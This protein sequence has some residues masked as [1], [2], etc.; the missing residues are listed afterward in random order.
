MTHQSLVHELIEKQRPFVE[1]LAKR[2]AIFDHLQTKDLPHLL[3]L[4]E[5]VD[6][7]ACIAFLAAT[8]EFL[9]RRDALRR[10]HEP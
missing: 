2:A 6:C 4:A 10:R 8:A 9:K 5:M 3:M 7:E 1:E